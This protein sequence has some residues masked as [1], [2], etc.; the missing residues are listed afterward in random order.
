MAEEVVQAG[1]AG[2][3]PLKVRG[4]LLLCVQWKTLEDLNRKV[5]W[6][7]FF[8]KIILDFYFLGR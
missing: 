4:E 3:C 6:I 7:T 8:K 2:L 1:T 5:M